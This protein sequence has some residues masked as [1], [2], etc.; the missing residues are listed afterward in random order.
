MVWAQSTYSHSPINGPFSSFIIQPV[1]PNDH[2]K[3]YRLY[4]NRGNE[5][6][7]LIANK[8]DPIWYSGLICTNVNRHGKEDPE[9]NVWFFNNPKY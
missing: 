4:V 2:S 8:T 1:N 7:Y 9:K 5:K 3:G 6:P